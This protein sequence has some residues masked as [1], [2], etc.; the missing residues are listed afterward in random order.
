MTVLLGEPG[1]EYIRYIQGRS[2]GAI[3]DFRQQVGKV[4]RCGGATTK[5]EY[6]EG[7][8]TNSHGGVV[9]TE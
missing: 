6:I 4:P 7:Q 1:R 2:Q 9:I 3:G 8:L 5:T